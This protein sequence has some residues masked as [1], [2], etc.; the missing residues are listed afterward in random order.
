MKKF[1]V[2]GFLCL[3]LI[4]CGPGTQLVVRPDVYVS[5]G[6][7]PYWSR[8]YDYGVYY[9]YS[10]IVVINGT[11]FNLDVRLDSRPI[12]ILPPGEERKASVRV[13]YRESRRVVVSVRAYANRRLIGTA[14]KI[15]HFYGTAD[16]KR[17]EVW[18]IR[19][20]RKL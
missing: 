6:F 20:I 4:S 11:P 15:F 12:F 7:Y 8:Y 10:D 19:D 5:G 14:S 18:H 16:Q 9:L 2:F 3:L 1:L 17:T 13:D